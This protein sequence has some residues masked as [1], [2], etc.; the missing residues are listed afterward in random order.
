MHLTAA[1]EAAR[2]CPSSG[3]F[4]VRLKGFVQIQPRHLPYGER[5]LELVWHK[6][7]RYC[8]ELACPRRTFTEQVR[9]VPAGARTT[10]RVRVMAGRRVRD[11]GSTVVQA[12]RDLPVLAHGDDAFRTVG[13]EGTA[14]LEP[15]A[16]DE[17]RQG[18]MQGSRIRTPAGGSPWQTGGTPASWTLSASGACSARARVA[19][20]R[21]PRTAGADGPRPGVEQHD[22]ERADQPPGPSV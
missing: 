4:A 14:A 13:Q 16:V 7:R 18:R 20:P 2:V 21:T 6:R 22:V 15:V 10:T 3:V 9:Q 19:L 11:S 17:T 8:T 5:R 12:A 1:D